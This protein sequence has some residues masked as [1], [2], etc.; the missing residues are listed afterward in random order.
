MTVALALAC[1]RASASPLQAGTWDGEIDADFATDSYRVHQDGQT[2]QDLTARRR[3]WLE[4]LSLYNRGWY[5]YDPRLY[6][7]NVGFTLG[8]VQDHGS[9][10][11]QSDSRH[12]RLLGYS[13][14]S[15]LFAELP[16]S[17]QTYTNRS[18]RYQ[19]LPFSRTQAALRNVG[20]VVNLREDSALRRFKLRHLSSNLRLEEQRLD[21]T[22]TPVAGAAYRRDELRRTL[23]WEVADGFET[24]DLD[25]RL[26]TDDFSNRVYPAGSYRAVNAS[27]NF[28]I[29]FGSRLNRR[30]D[31]HVS[32]STRSGPYGTSLLVTDERLHV[33][34]YANLSTEAMFQSIRVSTRDSSATTYTGSSGVNYHPFRNL[35]TM[36][37]LSASR[38]ELTAG[39]R[40]NRAAQLLLSYEH[41]LPARG[42]FFVILT[43]RERID[44]NHL[45]AARLEVVD[46]GH[47]APAVLGAGAGFLLEQGFADPNSIEVVDARGGAR[48]PTAL[49]IDFELVTEGNRTRIVPMVTSVVIRPG[50]PLVVTYYF[51]VDPSIRYRTAGR[52]VSAGVSIR[53]VTA[54]VGRDVTTPTVVAGQDAGFLVEER[55]SRADLELAGHVAGLRSTTSTSWLR[56]DSNRLAYT[57]RRWSEL[58]QY[59]PTER[60]TLSLVGDWSVTNFDAPARRSDVKSARL[61]ADYYGPGGWWVTATLSR[62]TNR[63]TQLAAEAINEAQLR[64]RREYGRLTLSG[65]LTAGDRNRGGTRLQN[66]GLDINVTRRF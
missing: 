14:D 62:R 46:E 19:L 41:T 22:N 4:E 43:G 45:A 11:G 17:L 8:L 61:S 21:E 27:G 28:S 50:D 33:D 16:Y 12:S 60:T 34:H 57:Q 24:A 58:L 29:D 64:A 47:A 31:S 44:D 49:G 56:Y 38:T 48:L 36:L 26:Q 63:D 13:F 6:T 40:S 59:R 42:R 23:T 20:A 54:S 53:N 10:D 15:M 1:A 39:E 5:L 9:A 18:E 3:R 25:W 52:S 65:A 7:G 55:R 32:Q 30:F 66:W 51:Q 35:G 2:Q 37:D